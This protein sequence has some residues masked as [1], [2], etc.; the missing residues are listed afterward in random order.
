MFGNQSS[1][2]SLCTEIESRTGKP[3]SAEL[4]ASFLLP[5]PGSKFSE[6]TARIFAG[7][8]T[9]GSERGEQ[10]APPDPEQE[11]P[12]A[13]GDSFPVT[14]SESPWTGAGETRARGDEFV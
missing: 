14:P 7:I 9:K 3:K 2:I 8:G 5:Q 10:G 11:M 13:H 4:A 6:D 12:S 1:V